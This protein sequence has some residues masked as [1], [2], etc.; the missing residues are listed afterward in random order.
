VDFIAAALRSRQTRSL[1]TQHAQYSSVSLRAQHCH[2]G[3][4]A[5]I[6]SIEIVV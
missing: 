1:S 3:L 2:H 6:K 5:R 4:L